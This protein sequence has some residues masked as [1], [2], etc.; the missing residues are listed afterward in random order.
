MSAAT[1][2]GSAAGRSKAARASKAVPAASFVVPTLVDH[3]VSLGLWSASLTFFV[4]V[5]TTLAVGCATLGPDATLPFQRFFSKWQ[6]F[7][8]GS[9]WVA[10]V[11]PKVDPKRAYMFAQNHTNNFDFVLMNNAT[12]HY[13]Q[14][15]ELESHF[16]IPVYGWFM[17]ARGG[18][19][20]RAGVKGQSPEVMAHMRREVDAGH[21]ILVFPEGTRTVDGRVGRFRTGS[22]FIARDLGLPVCPVAVTGAFDMMRKG[23]ALLRPGHTLTVWVDEPVETAGLP[24]SAIPELAE[25]VRSVVAG[26]IDDYWRERGWEGA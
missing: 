24:D 22:F 20:V 18:I 2:L 26:R 1:Q 3:A 19:P 11:H 21:C 16:K 13:K 6:I 9:R 5:V 23:S 7:L 17:K 8:T 15:V 25:H 10:N 12:P 14:G 4:P